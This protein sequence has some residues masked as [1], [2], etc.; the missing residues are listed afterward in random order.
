[1]RIAEIQEHAKDILFCFQ[2]L[3]NGHSDD[4]G[5]IIREGL[6]RTANF[7]DF[8]VNELTVAENHWHFDDRN[9][10]T[11]AQRDR[12]WDMCGNYG[13]PFNEE[14]Y[15]VDQDNGY[16]E[17]W[18]GGRDYASRPNDPK[19]GWGKTTIYV[20]VSPEGDSHT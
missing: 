19:E 9:R 18:V 16:A 12:L 3:Q 15:F 1:M 2:E 6:K 8:L 7:R 10:M 11:R 17:G 20:G 13:V 14:H 4:E 5:M